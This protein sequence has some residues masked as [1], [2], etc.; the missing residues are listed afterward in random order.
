MVDKDNYNNQ[1]WDYGS[2]S[3][4]FTPYPLEHPYHRPKTAVPS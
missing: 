4:I 1:G 3:G 2:S